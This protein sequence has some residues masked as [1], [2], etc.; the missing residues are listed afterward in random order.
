MMRMHIGRPYEGENLCGAEAVAGEG[1]ATISDLVLH[2]DLLNRHTICEKCALVF[3]RDFIDEG[4]V[5]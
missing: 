5:E 3:K 2:H 4:I 1:W